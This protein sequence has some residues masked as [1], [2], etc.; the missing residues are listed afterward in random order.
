LLF[1]WCDFGRELRQRSFKLVMPVEH[2]DRDMGQ[3]R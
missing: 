1:F 2:E 3:A